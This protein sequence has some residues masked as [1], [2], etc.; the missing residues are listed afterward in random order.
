MRRNNIQK[1]FADEFLHL[2]YNKVVHQGPLERN[3]L[4][5]STLRYRNVYPKIQTRGLTDFLGSG[6]K[7]G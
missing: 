4:G 7:G 2:V 1:P 3:V 5:A 6:L